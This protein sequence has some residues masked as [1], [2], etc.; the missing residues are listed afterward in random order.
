VD[1]CDSEV[2]F[3]DQSIDATEYFYFFDNRQFTTTEANFTHQYTQS[4]GDYPIQ[5][6]TNQYGCSDTA[7]R[8]VFVE[9]FS[10]YVPNT[11]IPDGNQLND[12]FIPMTAYDVNGWQFQ[13][14]NK[15]GE[16]I[17]ETEQC[18]Q[19]WDGTFEG[20]PCQ[21]GTYI[22]VLKYKPCDN[23]YATQQITGFV[24]LLR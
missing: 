24:N 13:I 8:E 18:D 10:I 9:P 21:D 3:I 20:K 6:V 7:V 4:G 11:F 5:I 19:G 23:P 22:Y 16:L 17:F 14:F 15:W 12:L 1:I 2:H